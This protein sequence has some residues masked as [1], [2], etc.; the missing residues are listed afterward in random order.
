MSQYDLS[1][2]AGPGGS[3]YADD[4]AAIDALIHKLEETDPDLVADVHGDDGFHTVEGEYNSYCRE[5]IVDR[6]PDAPFAESDH[7][8][9]DTAH[10]RSMI[11]LRYNGTRGSSGKG[12]SHPDL[13]VGFTGNDPR[14]VDNTPRLDEVRRQM[15]ARAG[16]MQVQMTDNAIS[17]EA[18]RPWSGAAISYGMKEIQ[19][20]VKS[21]AKI[22]AGQKTAQALSNNTG[23]EGWLHRQSRAGVIAGGAEGMG[24][25]AR[26]GASGDQGDGSGATGGAARRVDRAT[27]SE[28]APWRH[29][30][31]D[32]NLAVQQ[33]GG[34]GGARARGAEADTQGGGRV[35]A[36]RAEQDYGEQQVSAATRKRVVGAT[37]A[38][39]ARRAATA[40]DAGRA[41]AS[42]Y[43][44]VGHLT[45]ATPAGL[46][47]ARDVGHALRE[48]HEDGQRRAGGEVQDSEG[49]QLGAARGLTLAARPGRAIRAS[50]STHCAAANLDF[51][52]IGAVVRGL[53][54]GT[55]SARRKIA[56]HVVADGSRTSM[57]A[58]ESTARM[59][60]A[61]LRTARDATAITRYSTA[62]MVSASAA[63]GLVVHVY[64]QCAPG[65]DAS[66]VRQSAGG[67]DPQAWAEHRD[68]QMAGAGLR[69]SEMRAAQGEAHIGLDDADTFGSAHST[70]RHSSLAPAPCAK[71]V[72]AGAWSDQAGMSDEFAEE[73][74]GPQD[75]A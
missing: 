28:S 2:T 23:T 34:G 69:P 67:N 32:A 27:D 21:S 9:H 20:R 39:A 47:I 65:D 72:R 75:D 24:V 33:Y 44:D 50:H 35:R 22:F 36:S 52:N 25:A 63:D 61:G 5:E 54:E 18:D 60:G 73:F 38:D 51:A 11:N 71:G 58:N 42:M 12:P 30:T 48:Q 6:Q 26:F 37:L 49:G 41:D 19:K 10:S 66:R 46:R 8:R 13:F 3:T 56:K 45:N 40:R 17:G 70:E 31:G 16:R 29:T 14:G 59:Q 1:T 55:A 64:A 7:A 4:G 15:G 74:S 62:A 43:A 53:R 57:Y 68:T